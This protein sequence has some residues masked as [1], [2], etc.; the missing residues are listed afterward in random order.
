MSTTTRYLAALCI[1][2]ICAGAFAQSGAPRAL[3]KGLVLDTV[4]RYD[5]HLTLRAH[6]NGTVVHLRWAPSAPLGWIN[7]NGRGYRLD[8]MDLGLVS[9]TTLGGIGESVSI[10][11]VPMKPLD[12]P[13]WRALH[14]QLPNDNYVMVAGEMIHE[15]LQPENM[16]MPNGDML[17]AANT[18]MER[19]SFAL[20]S[21]DLSWPAAKGSALGMEDAT[22]QPGH[23]YLYRVWSDVKP[24]VVRM[25]TAYLV[26][27]TSKPQQI[28]KPIIT[29]VVERDK[30]IVLNWPRTAHEHYFTAYDI[31]RSDDGGKSFHKLNEQPYI[32]FTN[33]D[34]PQR[35][36]LIT[37]TDSVPQQYK[38]YQYRLIGHTPFG[39]EG[40]PS[41][42]VKGMA[43]DRTGPPAPVNVKAIEKKAGEIALSWEYPPDVKDLRGFHVVRGGEVSTPNTALTKEMLPAKARSFTDRSPELHKHNYYMV[44][45]VDTAGNPGVSLSALGD[46]LDSIPPAAPTGITG[47]IDTSGVVTLKWRLGKEPDLFGYYVYFRNQKDHIEARV[48]GQPL[49]DTVFTDTISMHTLTEHIYYRVVA[50]DMNENQSARGELIELQR[51]DVRPPNTPVFTDYRVSKQGIWMKWAPSSS[52]DVVAHLL[53]RR[54]NSRAKWDTLKV[55]DVGSK[56]REYL[57][58]D[59]GKGKIFEYAI[60]AKDDVGLF[61]K[62]ER[63]FRLR[64]MSLDRPAAVRDLQAKADAQRKQL[65]LSWSYEGPSDAWF[66]VMRSGPNGKY[67]SLCSLPAETRQWTDPTAKPDVT[68]KYMVQVRAADGATSDYASATAKL[69]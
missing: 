44:V 48:N 47:R 35:K 63:G 32:H 36:D 59:Q 24:D 31:E 4:D 7:A 3:P 26:V 37:Y 30:V 46:V 33:P 61:S 29:E 25:D 16:G 15:A 64:M 11:A 45:A 34:L 54:A 67:A 20:L 18:F 10:T 56:L 57:D 58:P 5:T 38:S 66:I 6:Y 2:M 50:I 55:F 22:V 51:P 62:R 69:R 52:E 21:A 42:A 53:L 13:G 23:R 68:Y 65:Q 28:P 19:M 1:S 40:P 8:R 41:D 49:R 27:S 60:I 12:I 39:I 9:D 14:D 43:R 17:G